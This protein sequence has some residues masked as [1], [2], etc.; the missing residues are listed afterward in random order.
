MYYKLA[1]ELPQLSSL[2]FRT[3]KMTVEKMTKHAMFHVLYDHFQQLAFQVLPGHLVFTVLSCTK[4]NALLSITAH[5]ACQ[6][7]CLSIKGCTK[8]S[9]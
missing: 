9:Q 1:E 6:R 5:I 7:G 8:L 3:L 2:F 4:H